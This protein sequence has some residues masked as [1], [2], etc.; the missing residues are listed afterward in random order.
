MRRAQGLGQRFGSVGLALGHMGYVQI[1]PINVCGRMHDH[2]LR[3]RVA[4]YAEGGLGAHLHPAQPSPARI[5]FEHHLPRT[6]VLVAFPLEAWPHLLSS[7]RE[8]E[9]TT[10]A[11]MGR[12]TPRERGLAAQI[13][14][15]LETGGPVGPE[16]FD[17][18]RRGRRVWGQSTLAKATLQKLFFHG[19]VLIAGRR[20]NRRLYDL[21]ERVLPAGV[22]ELPPPPAGETLRWLALLRLRQHRLSP[23]TAAERRSL[24]GLAVPVRVPGCAPLFCLAEDEPSLGESGGAGDGEPLL[25]APL[26][27]LIYNRR[28]TR[29]LWGFDYTWEAYTPPCRRQ[30]GYY[31]LPVL[32]GT[33]LVGHLD[34][35]A[36]RHAGRLRVVS[37][38][39]RRGHPTAGALR[40][41]AGFLGLRP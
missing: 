8:R 22:L 3:N 9:R 18:E 24:G 5:A 16:D 35:K 4:G 2:I 38:R 19:R 27:P 13:L 39:V 11:W 32:S 23:L 28:L 31:A 1:D 12:L 36:D 7:M 15:R 29:E 25:L 40:R 21:P 6:H 34:L 17:D 33:D 30:R 37:R 26:D 41:L 14:A 10:G 20:L